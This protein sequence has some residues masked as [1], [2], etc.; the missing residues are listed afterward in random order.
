MSACY[1]VTLKVKIL[2]EQGAINALRN[3]IDNDERTN[4]S[5]D[6]YEKDGITTETFDD[7]TRIFLAGWKG[8]EVE[9]SKCNNGFTIYENS[10]N[11]SYGWESV[12]ME[13]FETLTPFLE[14]D[15]K[16]IIYPDSDYDELIVENRKCVQIH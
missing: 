13:M 11:A 16:L 4:Y 9:I 15:S 14:D 6:E 2:D 12:M 8:Q 5:L 3:H 7:L 10:F 1:D